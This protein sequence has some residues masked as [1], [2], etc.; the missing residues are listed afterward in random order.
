MRNLEKICKYSAIIH[1]D[2]GLSIM[3]NNND[4]NIGG[5]DSEV[6]KNPITG[7]VYIPGSSIKGKIRS[8]LELKKGIQIKTDRKGNEYADP[9]GCGD[10]DICRIFGAHLNMKA[11]SAPTRIIVRDAS[12]TESS[13]EIIK[14]MPLDKG[15]YLE[16]KA[17]NSINRAKGTANSPRFFERIPAGLEF[18][19]EI[20]LQIFDDDNEESLKS[21]LEEGLT[22]L[23]NNYLGGNGTRGYGKISIL[24]GT[25]TEV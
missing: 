20:L 22:L 10:R 19:L 14:N 16:I 15:G 1:L 6:I 3:G 12:L 5:V 24:N 17:E 4:I 21:K 25:W 8:L 7:E 18:N 23:Q 13:K 9:C 2:T 11:K